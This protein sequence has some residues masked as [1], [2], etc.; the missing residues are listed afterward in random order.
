I[1]GEFGAPGLT[2]RVGG[3]IPLEL[4]INS[5]VKADIG[6]AEAISMPVLLVLLLIIFGGFAAA[7]LPLAIGGSCGRP[8]RSASRGVADL[9]TSGPR[10]TFSVCRSEPSLWCSAWAESPLV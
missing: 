4:A 8:A 3:Q 5:E 6:R 10:G 7:G 2:T 1:S 9:V